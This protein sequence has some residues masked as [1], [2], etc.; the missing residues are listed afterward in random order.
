MTLECKTRS[1]EKKNPLK[2]WLLY[3]PGKNRWQT[4][5]LLSLH[6]CLEIY[7]NH[8]PDYLSLSLRTL[9]LPGSTVLSVDANEQQALLSMSSALRSESYV[10]LRCKTI[11]KCCVLI[12]RGF[13]IVCVNML[14]MNV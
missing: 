8:Y 11:I 13:G 5:S 9:F 2:T 14:S 1:K 7:T 6:F 12:Q 10:M 4:H 3:C